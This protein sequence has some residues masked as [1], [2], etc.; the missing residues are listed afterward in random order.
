MARTPTQRPDSRATATAVKA[1]T[2]KSKAVEKPRE[3]YRETVEAVAVAFILALLVRGFEAEAFVIPT[4]SMAPTLMGRHKEITC[5]QCGYVYTVNASEEVEGVPTGS[6]AT[7][8]VHTGICV[9][10]RY[11]A[12]VA[13]APSFKGD[14]ILVMKFNYDMPFLPGADGPKRWDVVVFRYPEEPE[15]SYIKRLVGLP[16][17]TVRVYYGDISI[18]AP[19]ASDFVQERRP[20]EHQQAMQM[21]VYDDAHRAK[22]LKDRPEWQR[23]ASQEPSGWSELKDTP[24]TYVAE[25]KG[26]GWTELRYRHLVPD[27]QQWRAI[28]AGDPLATGPRPTLITDFYSYN[29]N[30]PVGSS[31]LAGDVGRDQESAW[32][33]PHWVSDLTLSARVDT[34]ESSKGQV[35]FELVEGEVSNRCLIDVE[36]GEAVVTHGGD[37]LGRKPH[38]WERSG[39]HDVTFANVDNRLTLWVD[40]T[41][42][43]GDGLTYEDAQDVHPDPTVEDLAPARIAVNG[44][45]ARVSGL[46][47]KRDIYYTQNP[48]FSDYGNTWDAKMPRNPTEL[49]ALLADPKRVAA[50][51]PMGW[52]DYPIGEDRFFMMG[53]NSPRSKDSR[54]WHN[55]DR[56][57]DTTGRQRWEVP[58][59]MLTGKAFCIYWPHGK[60]FGPDIRLWSDFRVP[61]R[62][63]F[64]R[65]TWIH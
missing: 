27:P 47:L 15:V 23:W 14:R 24:G 32:L 43:F 6:A 57:W 19:G 3:S 52:T 11:Q 44:A 1:E 42:V 55:D 30:L 5:P 37:V 53:D 22:L 65:M 20:L 21:M 26:Q 58:R 8:R 2:S 60:P 64:E 17:D 35:R 12:R 28:E 51:G 38:V 31:D 59:T 18:R 49:T 7:R 29:T 33:Q 34:Q 62:P 4:G 61:F 63:Y 13:D 45:R 54:G 48:G 10:C 25:G 46:V 16:G 41:P 9:N 40:G 50:L 36:T 39:E 56:D